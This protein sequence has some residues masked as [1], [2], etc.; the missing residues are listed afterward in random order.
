M[1]VSAADLHLREDFLASLPGVV[2]DAYRSWEQIYSYAIKE[3]ASGLVLAGDIFD[4]PP[5]SKDVAQFL[6]GA[7]T[8]RGAGIKIYAIQG[9]HG[10]AKLPWTS[11]DPTNSVINLDLVDEPHLIEEG[12]FISGYDALPPD[13]LEKRLKKHKKS[14]KANVMVLHQMAKGCLPEIEGK[15]MWDYDPAWVPDPIKLVLLGDYHDRWFT[16]TNKDQTLHIYNGSTYMRAINERPDKRFLRVDFDGANFKATSIELKTRP[17]T[18][19]F[20]EV[21]QNLKEVLRQISLQPAKALVKVTYDPDIAD[22]EAKCRA[23]VKDGPVH[24]YFKALSKTMVDPER[25]DVD[26]L[27]EISMNGCLDVMVDRE[28]DVE[29]H[30]FMVALLGN[31]DTQEV[32]DSTKARLVGMPELTQR[33]DRCESIV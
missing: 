25:F 22:V 21:E 7:H 2:G 6:R 17:F 33:G 1:F 13:E 15:Q 16:H 31:P 30:S 19:L 20:L 5:S 26:K 11:I 24:F 10:R 9:Q 3:K 4:G 8:L 32:L 28:T 23:A 18:E 14:N 27:R 12:V 29:F